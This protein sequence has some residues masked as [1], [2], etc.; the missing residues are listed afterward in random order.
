MRKKNELGFNAFLR[1]TGYNV[2]PHICG[3]L[4]Q[5]SALLSIVE[6][7][8]TASVI[9]YLSSFISMNRYLFLICFIFFCQLS[10]IS[11]QSKRSVDSLLGHRI[12]NQEEQAI[13]AKEAAKMMGKDVYLYD[14]V[15][16]YRTINDSLTVLTVGGLR[17]TE[18]ILIL[19]KGS[20]TNRECKNARRG[21]WHFGG[22]V[23]KYKGRPAIV[24]TRAEQ[25]GTRIQI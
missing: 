7:C 9:K 17:R 2:E 3:S 6:G 8:A 21:K 11:A 1:L 18:Q 20:E 22:V 23:S 13:T 5:Q 25:L 19:I 14:E 12:L 15:R 10:K 24:V 4:T 16:S